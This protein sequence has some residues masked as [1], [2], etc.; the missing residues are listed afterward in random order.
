MRLA[1]LLLPA[2]L[3]ALAGAPAA[4]A[5]PFDATR[6]AA[7][8]LGAWNRAEQRSV[9]QAR[10]LAPL[11]DGGFH[12]ERAVTGAQLRPAL[13]ALA[14][15]SRAPRVVV[16]S[17]RLSVA[18]FDLVL[19]RQLGLTDLAAAVQ[20]EAARA[21]LEPP[22][23]FGTEVVARQLALRTNHPSGDDALELYPWEPVTRAEAAHSLATVAA[24][25]G[26]EVPVA[27]QVLGRFALPR[28]T[29]AQRRVLRYAVR[30]I[31]MPYV[32]GGEL[33]SG[34][35]QLGGQ[36]RGGYDCSGLVWRVFKLSG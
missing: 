36:W 21:G 2:V 6:G 12:G 20:A 15:T 33:D 3:L 19:V 27:R 14:A 35:A 32:W 10:L 17:G 13:R 34:S 16:P 23:R 1:R 29:A 22:A 9:A 28:Y 8:A 24:F 18:T 5:A 26:W 4:Q 30:F 31:G 11:P 25:R 7:P